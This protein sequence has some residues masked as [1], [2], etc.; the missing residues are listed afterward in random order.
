MAGYL[1]N[2]NL[3]MVNPSLDRD[4]TKLDIKWYDLPQKRNFGGIELYLGQDDTLIDKNVTLRY[5]RKN[6]I[7]FKYCIV[8]GMDHG[9]PF[10][11]YAKI[12]HTSKFI[13]IINE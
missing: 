1:P 10:G 3:I 13:P 8:P 5:L 4:L 12:L 6:N 9:T 2:A 11:Y 7:N